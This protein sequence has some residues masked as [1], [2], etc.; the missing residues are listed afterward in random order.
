MS[1]ISRGPARPNFLILDETTNHLNIETIEALE[2]ALGRFLV[3][4]TCYARNQ[5]IYTFT[6]TIIVQS[7]SRVVSL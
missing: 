1:E 4:L 7:V 6:F 3:S 2:K 5:E